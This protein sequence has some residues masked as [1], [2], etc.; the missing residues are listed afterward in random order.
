MLPL[1]HLE[2]VVTQIDKT[3]IRYITFEV[4]SVKGITCYVSDSSEKTTGLEIGMDI[5]LEEPAVLFENGRIIYTISD[6]YGFVSYG[7]VASL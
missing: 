2:G 5:C 4:L 7:D 3:D 6:E 1:G